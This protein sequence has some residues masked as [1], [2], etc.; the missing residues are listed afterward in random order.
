MN[1]CSVYKYVLSK[2]F[3][4]T[5]SGTLMTTDKCEDLEKVGFIQGKHYLTVNLDNAEKEL[6]DILENIK[7]YEN[8]AKSARE[9]TLNKHTISHRLNYIKEIIGGL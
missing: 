9:V 4:I 7:E 1:C 5:G 8:I 2:H 3:E 6:N